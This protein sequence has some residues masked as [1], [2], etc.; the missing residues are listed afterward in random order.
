MTFAPL[1]F[2]TPKEVIS[3]FEEFSKHHLRKYFKLIIFPKINLHL[4]ACNM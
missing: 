4:R 3:F 2:D 1:L